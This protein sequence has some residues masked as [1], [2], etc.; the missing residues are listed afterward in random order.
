MKIILSA[1]ITF[2]T[3]ALLLT[4]KG[5]ENRWKVLAGYALCVIA[6]FVFYN[7]KTADLI[8]PFYRPTNQLFYQ[9][10]FL[11][12]GEY[13][14]SLLPYVVGG[15]TIHLPSYILD[16]LPGKE[17]AEAW[18]TGEMFCLNIF[19][20][21]KN[22]GAKT[23]IDED[24]NFS[25]NIGEASDFEDIGYLN[26]AFRYSFLYNNSTEKYGNSFYYYWFY[27]DNFAPFK[28]YLYKDGLM[29]NDELY[30]LVGSDRS[31]YLM[32]HEVYLKVRGK[33]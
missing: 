24:N 20:V 17:S 25:M 30:L 31:L 32:P 18:Q 6:L 23:V 1:T 13:T 21:M 5:K 3:F 29:E 19:E 2:I 9:P 4:K 27:G 7:I 26:D 12:E 28:M 14:D 16:E 22:C 8:L 10:E 11:E 33:V 15:K